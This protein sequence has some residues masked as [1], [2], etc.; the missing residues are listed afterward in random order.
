MPTKGGVAKVLTEVYAFDNDQLEELIEA[1]HKEQF[2]R[3][4][5]EQKQ[6]WEAIRKAVRTYIEKWGSIDVYDSQVTLRVD[7]CS[8]F[9]SVGEI[10]TEY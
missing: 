6:D 1:L 4:A 3:K 9:S 5:Q 7:S 8:D 2:N 10:D